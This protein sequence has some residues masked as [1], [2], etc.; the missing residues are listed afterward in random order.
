MVPVNLN[1]E[2]TMPDDANMSAEQETTEEEMSQEEL[3]NLFA[4]DESEDG[5]DLDEDSQDDN[6]ELDEGD[7]EEDSDEDDAEDDGEEDEEDSDDEEDAEEDEDSDDP[8]ADVK[9][10]AAALRKETQDA[11]TTAAAETKRAE[12]ME[13]S[14]AELLKDIFGSDKVE[15]DGKEVDLEKFREDYGDDLDTLITAR[16]YQIAEPLVAKA[17]EAGGFASQS[18]L[19]AIKSENEEFR[20]MSQVAQSHPEIW[21]LKADDKFWGWVDGQGD[22]TKTLME[23]GGVDGVSAVIGAYKKANIKKANEGIDKTAAKKKKK[24]TDLHSSTMRTKSTK[25]SGK[26]KK[27]GRMSA[28]EEK[29][30]FDEAEVTD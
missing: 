29:V 30:A 10:K 15:I 16:A 2:N 19:Q 20:F 4:Q 11:E 21:Q 12:T 27:P 26:A 18:E 23:Q 17:M 7:D 9:A 24:H 5:N 6:E 13:T 14:K 1:K 28:A 8:L 3:D 22:D 25:K